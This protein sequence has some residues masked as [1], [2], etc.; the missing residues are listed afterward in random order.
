MNHC[1]HHS[2]LLDIL[3]PLIVLLYIYIAFQFFKSIK[4]IP[5][6]SRDYR[7]ITALAML[8]LI[9]L[10]CAVSGYLS[11]W[12]NF[13]TAIQEASHLVLVVVSAVFI[14]LNQAAV[15]GGILRND[16]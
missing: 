14:R 13:S 8:V 16:R 7:A 9:F 15:I 5:H 11:K 10:F 12:L 2:P 6:E 4:A 1:S 3:M